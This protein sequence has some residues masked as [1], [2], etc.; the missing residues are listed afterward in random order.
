[1]PSRHEYGTF[2]TH[3]V[4][5]ETGPRQMVTPW[6]IRERIPAFPVPSRKELLRRRE[7]EG[8][9]HHSRV[10][11]K[12]RFP[13]AA[14]GQQIDSPL[15]IARGNG[16]G[17][18]REKPRGEKCWSSHAGVFVALLL[19][20]GRKTSAAFS[21]GLTLETRVDHAAAGI[22]GRTACRQ[23]GRPAELA[24]EDSRRRPALAGAPLRARWADKKT[25]G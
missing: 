17:S 5:V 3:R 4:A 11:Q 6:Q 7:T 20:S 18:V 24:T 10:I 2:D 8:R 13:C 12:E 21:G 23:G 19:R 25:L 16:L 14:G 22:T 15:R 1:M 9:C